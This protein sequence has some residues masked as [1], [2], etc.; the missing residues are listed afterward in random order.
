MIVGDVDLESFYW[1]PRINSVFTTT[2]PRVLH[3]SAWFLLWYPPPPKLQGFQFCIIAT[4]CANFS[5]CK[6]VV[7]TAVNLLQWRHVY[8]ERTGYVLCRA[9]V[10]YVVHSLLV[11][12]SF[13]VVYAVHSIYSQLQ[14]TVAAVYQAVTL[15]Y[16]AL[17][18]TLTQP[19]NFMIK[20]CWVWKPA[21][22]HKS[23]VIMWDRNNIYLISHN[24]AYSA[25]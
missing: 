20:E 24:Y 15:F 18:R 25:W 16:Q 7:C 23:T 6:C 2:P 21:W 13:I 3:F 10:V 22:I 5:H 12:A 19:C 14:N 11:Q 17:R 9:L 8:I 1:K 4:C